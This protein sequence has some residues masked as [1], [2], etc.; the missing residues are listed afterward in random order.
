MNQNLLSKKPQGYKYLEVVFRPLDY[1]EDNYAGFVLEKVVY[2]QYLLHAFLWDRRN[3]IVFQFQRIQGGLNKWNIKP[4]EQMLS[5]TKQTTFWYEK[6]ELSEHEQIEA[7]ER[8]YKLTFRETLQYDVMFNN[9][10]QVMYE[11]LYNQK[12]SG[13]VI[14]VIN[15]ASNF[16]F[17]FIRSPKQVI[18]D[19]IDRLKKNK[20]VI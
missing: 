2:N 19:G 1:N 13:Q 14:Q 6:H 8:A 17:N 3:N 20:D 4:Y 12:C 18:K 7:L 9:C 11:V 10:Q 15:C 16:I 5:E